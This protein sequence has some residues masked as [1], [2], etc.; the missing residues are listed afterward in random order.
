MTEKRTT[1]IHENRKKDDSSDAQTTRAQPVP[2]KLCGEIIKARKAKSLTQEEV[3]EQ[4][5]LTP[6]FI[7][8]IEEGQFHRFSRPVFI[9]GYLR[10]YAKLVG[11][12]DDDVIAMYEAEFQTS[13]APH[14]FVEK[15][16]LVKQGVKAEALTG[17][18]LRICLA[19]I[20]VLIIIMALFWWFLAD[21]REIKAVVSSIQSTTEHQQI[22][23][24]F[25]GDR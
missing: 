19:S 5:H 4:L 9:K 22:E 8:Y 24:L 2:K 18:I 25:V 3:G 16:W 1:N 12:S 15:G 20:A 11:L 23:S 21:A 17:H 10:S 7:K 6:T 14:I 13:P